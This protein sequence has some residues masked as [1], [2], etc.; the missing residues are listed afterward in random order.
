M[1]ERLALQKSAQLEAHY[2]V[3]KSDVRVQR[4][5]RAIRGVH[6]QVNA[7]TAIKNRH[8]SQHILPKTPYESCRLQ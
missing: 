8:A 1:A 3:W 4:L 6:V 5:W 2:E 7:K